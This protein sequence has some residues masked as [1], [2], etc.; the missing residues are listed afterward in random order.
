MLG[1]GQKFPDYSLTGV[2]SQDLNKAFQTFTPDSQPGKWR[3]LFFWPKDFTFVCPTE[4]A[5]FGKLEKE[6][7]ARDAQLYGV[8][9]DSEYV[10]HAWRQAKEELKNLP[11]PMLADIKRELTTNLGVEAHTASSDD[12]D[13]ND[14]LF[15]YG[16]SACDTAATTPRAALPQSRRP[17]RRE[18]PR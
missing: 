3:V 1:I 18:H 12:P 9:I 8:S 11:F 13:Q 17:A 14:N 5:A 4:I 15:L 10:H 16:S 2:V 7:K 6:F